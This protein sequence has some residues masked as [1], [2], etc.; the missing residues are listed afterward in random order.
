MQNM[1]LTK[2]LAIYKDKMEVMERNAKERHI[3]C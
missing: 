1:A 2:D 3:L